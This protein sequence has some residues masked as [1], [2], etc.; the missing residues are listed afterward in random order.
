M[1]RPK[2][3][4]RDRVLEKAIRLFWKKG[5]E[6]SSMDEIVKTTGLNRFSL[7][8]E[9]GGKEGLFRSS[10]QRYM[11]EMQEVGKALGREPL[12][13]HN[14]YEYFNA[15]VK[16]KFLHGCLILNTMTERHVVAKGTFS[17][18]QEFMK[19]SEMQMVANLKA[20]QEQGDLRADTDVEGL[21]KT[22]IALDTGIIM[23]NI[24]GITESEKERVVAFLG[25]LLR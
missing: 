19:G 7:Y 21:A 17:D 11:Q 22:L 18:V 24:L 2:K 15:V 4:E 25:N 13:L 14:L 8:K 16:A 12:G 23:Y 1:G 3:Y 9:F 10:L 5:Y 6:G 20:A